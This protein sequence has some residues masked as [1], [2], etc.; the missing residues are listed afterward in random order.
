MAKLFGRCKENC[1]IRGKKFEKDQKYIF[2]QTEAGWE[3][4]EN[5]KPSHKFFSPLEIEP[6]FHEI[7]RL[8][9]QPLLE[10]G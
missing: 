1:Q 7:K 9:G 4:V 6:V 5:G 3:L 2:V 8:E 10:N